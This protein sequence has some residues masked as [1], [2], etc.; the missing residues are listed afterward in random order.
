[1]VIEVRFMFRRRPKGALDNSIVLN[2]YEYV[3]QNSW[4]RYNA[5]NF[6]FAYKKINGISVS[7]VLGPIVSI[8]NKP[9]TKERE[10]AFFFTQLKGWE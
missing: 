7:F 6:M 2:W 5:Q 9:V 10:I 4:R 8:E 3:Q 1:M